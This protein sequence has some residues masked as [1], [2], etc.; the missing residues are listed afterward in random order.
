[1]ALEIIVKDGKIIEVKQNKTKL[2]SFFQ[3]ELL[4]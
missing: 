3:P 2:N 1:M 4:E